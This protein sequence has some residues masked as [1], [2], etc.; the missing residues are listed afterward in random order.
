MKV[1]EMLKILRADGWF[2]VRQTGAAIV[3]L[4]HPVKSGT[5]TVAGKPNKTLHPKV[6]ASI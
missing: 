3:S 5:V 6:V 1:R 4:H 2:V